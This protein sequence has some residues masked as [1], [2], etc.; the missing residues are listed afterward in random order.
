[1]AH[2]STAM[3]L[4]HSK[5]ILFTQLSKFHNEGT[6][7]KLSCWGETLWISASLHGRILYLWTTI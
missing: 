6:C 7:R 3:W 2:H 4:R 5:N 1:M